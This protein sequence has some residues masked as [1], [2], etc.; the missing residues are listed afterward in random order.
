MNGTIGK[1]AAIGFG[2]TLMAIGVVLLVL[3]GPGLVL[4]FLG[5]GVLASHFVWARW[6]VKKV[7]QLAAWAKNWIAKKRGKTP[8]TPVALDGPTR[9]S[10]NLDDDSNEPPFLN[11]EP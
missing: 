7:K 9:T 6:L 3:P 2:L 10:G 5:V 11:R 4:I 8:V 1:I